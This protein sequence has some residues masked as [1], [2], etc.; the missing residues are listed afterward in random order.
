MMRPA[1]MKTATMKTAT[2][3][4]RRALQAVRSAVTVASFDAIVPAIGLTLVFLILAGLALAAMHALST[5]AVAL[6]CGA[7]VVTLAAV[8]V[9]V[10][11]PAPVLAERT[12]RRKPPNP[13]AVT[14]VLIFTVAAALA[15]RYSATSATAD[16]DGA[17]SV[18]I[19]AY[20]SGGRLHVGV[21]QAARHGAAPLRIV[22][23][24]AGVTVATWN[25]ISLAPG[26]TW[27]ASAPTVTGKGPAQVLALHGRT[28]MAS[29]LS[30]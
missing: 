2:T 14:G 25:D 10:S 28:V 15:V 19:W 24:Q 12:A 11:H 3:T 27:E 5:V 17:S 13:L 22:V 9:G 26:Q 23:T 8:W 20:P 18:A 16:A 7:G 21:E 1:T 4:G 30:R 6:V 29:L